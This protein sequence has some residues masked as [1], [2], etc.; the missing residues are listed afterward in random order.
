MSTP[1]FFLILLI[2]FQN[3]S[4]SRFYEGLKNIAYRDNNNNNNNNNNNAR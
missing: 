3:F 4:H 1:N 2:N